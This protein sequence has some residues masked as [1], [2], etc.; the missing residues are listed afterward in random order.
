MTNAEMF[1]DCQKC[2]AVDEIIQVYA[3][4]LSYLDYKEPIHYLCE[5]CS[6][7]LHMRHDYFYLTDKG[8]GE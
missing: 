2:G 6:L 4:I 7:A 5:E 8:L 3:N 1:Q